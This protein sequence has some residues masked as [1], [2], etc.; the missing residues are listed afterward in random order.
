MCTDAL[1]LN[2]PPIRN[3]PPLVPSSPHPISPSLLEQAINIHSTQTLYAS[4]NIFLYLADDIERQWREQPAIVNPQLAATLSRNV[5]QFK[6]RG[7]LSYYELL[8][9][10]TL[11]FQEVRET[12]TMLTPPTPDLPHTVYSTGIPEAGI[13]SVASDQQ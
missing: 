5:L 6:E 7:A 11:K 12:F 9:E 10:M 2:N 1:T 4:L 13:P 3:S 8:T